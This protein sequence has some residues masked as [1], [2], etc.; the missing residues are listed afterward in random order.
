MHSIAQIIEIILQSNTDIRLKELCY[1]VTQK[2][3]IL[4]VRGRSER[5]SEGLSYCSS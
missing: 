4:F 1:D 2:Y 3:N 5:R